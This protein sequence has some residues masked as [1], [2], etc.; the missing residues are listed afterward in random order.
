LPLCDRAF[1]S[2]GH[3]A[4]SRCAIE[5][6]SLT[7]A[8]SKFGPVLRVDLPKSK[9]TNGSMGFAFV[10]F[11]GGA[12]AVPGGG[13]TAFSD[14]AVRAACAGLDGRSVGGTSVKVKPFN[15]KLLK[16]GYKDPT[17]SPPGGG[18]G[19]DESDTEDEEESSSSEEEEEADAA[20]GEDSSSE[21]DS[22]EDEESS[23]EE[24]AAAPAP[25]PKRAPAPAPAP[26]AAAPSP[27]G[28]LKVKLQFGTAVKVVKLS[29]D[30]AFEDARAAMAAKC[31]KDAAA[32]TLSYEDADGDEVDIDDDEVWQDAISTAVADTL[33]LKG[34]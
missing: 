2:F 31:G 14:K 28:G 20:D 6:S 30:S 15:R 10:W 25:A 26:A 18:S 1:V 3:R 8:F 17:G 4:A 34:H 23:S 22:S 29:A 11:Q 27:G 21:E 9:A 16:A 5:A 13:A 24:E 7:K 33:R 19:A 12:G 32:L